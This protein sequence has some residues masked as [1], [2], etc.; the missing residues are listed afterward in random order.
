LAIDRLEVRLDPERK[1]KLVALASQQGVPLSETVRR[2]IDEAYEEIRHQRRLQA[3][4][5][6]SQMEIED[7]PD[8]DE[9]SRQLAEAHN[10]GDLY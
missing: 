5:A 3:V 8:P 2:L 6:I 10:P 9:L 7:V 1:R 4:L